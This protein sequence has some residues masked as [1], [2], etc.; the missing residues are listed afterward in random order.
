MSFGLPR[1]GQLRAW[2]Q[3][4]SVD[5]QHNGDQL[6]KLQKG[7]RQPYIHGYYQFDGRLRLEIYF[8]GTPF[9]NI[10]ITQW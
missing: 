8:C 2:L 6:K 1:T 9:S 4:I 3:A 5:F 7:W 10:E